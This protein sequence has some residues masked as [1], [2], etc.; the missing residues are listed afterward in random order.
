MLEACHGRIRK[1]CQNLIRLVSHLELEGNCPDA[2][3]SAAN[4]L[5]YFDQAAPAHHH[6]EEEDLFPAL[7]EAIKGDS[8]EVAVLSAM[9][10]L[11]A[12]HSRM[13]NDWQAV[14][15][16]LKA[17]SEGFSIALNHDG[18]ATRFAMNYLQHAKEEE[19]LVYPHAARLLNAAQL[20]VISGQMVARRQVA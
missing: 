10:R 13:Y 3:Q 8:E 14:R 5:R 12:E 7:K 15:Q 16:R 17:L 19:E 9:A 1:F 6:D 11:E 2:M 4:I 20:A 18:V